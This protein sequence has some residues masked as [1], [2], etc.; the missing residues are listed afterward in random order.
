M[1]IHIYLYIYIYTYVYIYI[2]VY[3]DIYIHIYIHSGS[4]LRR[5]IAPAHHHAPNLIQ[6]E[7][8]NAHHTPLDRAPMYFCYLNARMQDCNTLQRYLGIV[9]DAAG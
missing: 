6:G 5:A 9:W 7:R 1:Y 3:I 4:R 8:L 2:Y